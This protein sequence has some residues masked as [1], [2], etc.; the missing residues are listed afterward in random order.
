MNEELGAELVD[1][2]GSSARFFI[3]DV[4]DTK[5]ISSAVQ[6]TANWVRETR[7]PLGGIIPAAGVGGAATVRT[8]QHPALHI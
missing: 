6:G 2:L 7:K 8:I 1:E 3:C 4:L 5:S